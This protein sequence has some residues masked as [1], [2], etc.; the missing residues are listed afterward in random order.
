[1]ALFNEGKKR[2]SPNQDTELWLV[3]CITTYPSQT[4]C[5]KTLIAKSSAI[6]LDLCNLDIPSSSSSSLVESDPAILVIV[7][8]NDQE[9]IELMS[10]DKFSETYGVVTEMPKDKL[11]ETAKSVLAEHMSSL[12]DLQDEIKK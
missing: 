12:K 6:K 4:W 9:T 1:M 8:L 3:L 10:I 2:L 5:A 7:M 11:F